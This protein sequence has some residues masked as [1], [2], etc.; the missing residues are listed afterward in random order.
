MGNK[1]STKRPRKR[2]ESENS[3]DPHFL[4]LTKLDLTAMKKEQRKLNKNSLHLDLLR[5]GKN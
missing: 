5:K 4:D 2:L 1:S 3:A